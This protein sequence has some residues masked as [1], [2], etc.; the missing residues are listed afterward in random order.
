MAIR[1]SYLKYLKT[2]LQILKITARISMC[3]QNKTVKKQRN[4]K[5]NKNLSLPWTP[6]GEKARG[7]H[8]IL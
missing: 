2:S 4:Q 1:I 7:S 3:I 5:L 6:Q 8:Q